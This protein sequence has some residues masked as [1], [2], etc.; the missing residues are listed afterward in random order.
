MIGAE[1]GFLDCLAGL[2]LTYDREEAPAP[3]SLVVKVSS[4]TERYRQIGDFYNAYEREAKFYEFAAAQS[5]IRLARCFG[6]EVDTATGAH[7]LYLEDLRS[8]SAGDQVRGLTPQQTGAC[9]ETIGR[10]HAAWWNSPQFAS[11]TWLPDRNLRAARYQAAWPKFHEIVGP[12]LSAGQRALGARLYERFDDCLAA[13]ERHPQTIAHSDFRADNLLFDPA[14]TDDPV[15]IVDWQ[16]ANR[17]NGLMDV[18]RLLCGSM[19]A[20]DRARCEFVLLRRYHEQLVRGG[21][22][23]YSFEQAVTAY[24][25]AV[26]LCLYYPVT[27][28]EAEE[29][30]GPRGQALAHAQIERFFAAAEQ[31]CLPLDD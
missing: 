2:T 25:Q 14:S 31:V 7:F 15:V 21:V 27:I 4:S 30:A 23:D 12:R 3:R 22:R 18:A 28:H 20:A 5:P 6:S 1:F 9:L 26:L 10:F 16:L 8:L 13:V 19:P 17:G 11:F 29:A 24:R